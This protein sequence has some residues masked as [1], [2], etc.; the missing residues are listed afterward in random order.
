MI[1]MHYDLLSILY[2]CYLRND[3]R[4]IETLRKN[5]NDNN[6]NGVIANL[7]FMSEEEMKDEMLGK[8]IDVVEMFKISTSLFKKFFPN[9]KA[10]FSIEGCDYI[11]DIN[12]LEK[13][14]KLGLSSILLVWNNKNKYGGGTFFKGG[15]TNEGKVFI[16]KAI[17]L[18]ICIDLS[19]MNEETYYDTVSLLNDAKNQGLNPKVIVSHSN[20]YDLYNHPRNIT[21][22]Q[23]EAI[24]KF[25]P[26]VGLVSYSFFLTK[27]DEDI[28]I[29]KQK[30]LKHIDTVIQILGIDGVGISTDDMSYDNVLFNNPIEK[31]IFPYEHLKK[32]LV[33]LLKTKYSDEEIN[34]ML[35]TNIKNKLF[36]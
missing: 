3:F 17:E 16:K 14:K 30:Y 6:V 15:L 25:N 34:K 23:I 10:I 19:H 22:K 26:V 29:L 20:V 5:F 33:K 4:Y 35:E 2:Y 11:K 27:D 9:L 21:V 8:K 18:G 12:E 1:D 7:Y 36:S 32:D 13:L 28:E 31:I 24:K